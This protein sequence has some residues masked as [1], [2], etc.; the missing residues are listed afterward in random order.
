MRNQDFLDSLGLGNNQP[1]ASAAPPKR[2]RKRASAHAVGR[3]EP[4]NIEPLTMGQRFELSERLRR[5]W[6]GRSAQLEALLTLVVPTKGEPP[7]RS[8]F[9]SPAVILSGP[10]GTG[11]R[12]LV[13][14][15]LSGRRRSDTGGLIPERRHECTPRQHHNRIK[16]LPS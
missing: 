1:S 10:S 11:K 3:Q 7:L 12:G 8:G 2:R 14:A 9:S 5:Q 13:R 6:P 15:V 16:A 4:G